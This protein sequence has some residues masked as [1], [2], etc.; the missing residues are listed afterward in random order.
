MIWFRI[1]PSAFHLPLF[2]FRVSSS[3]ICVFVFFQAA[4]NSSLAPHRYKIQPLTSIVPYSTSLHHQ[5][6]TK[7]IPC[8][9]SLQ[10]STSY[11]NRSLLHI[12]TPS[13]PNKIHPLLHIA[14]RF[15]LLHQSFLTPHRY[16]IQP[17]TSIVPYSTSLHHQPL[18]KVVPKS[19]SQQ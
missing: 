16:K 10:D 17:L 9:T 1:L 7:F 19:T 4:Q 3:A 5:P 18:T 2:I 8:S 12:A 11:I 14:T 6:L 15:S 13:T